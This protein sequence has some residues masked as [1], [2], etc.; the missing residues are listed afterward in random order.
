MKLLWSLS[1]KKNDAEAYINQLTAKGNK[2]EAYIKELADKGKSAHI[3]EK[4]S[5]SFEVSIGSFRDMASAQTE[6]QKAFKNISQQ[7]W[8]D[9]IQLNPN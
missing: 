8:I 2:A 4:S 7:T 3:V 6:K 5:H 1:A 9:T